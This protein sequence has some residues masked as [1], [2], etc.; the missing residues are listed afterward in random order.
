[1]D[2]TLYREAMARWASGV[3]IIACRHDARVIATTV[4]AFFSLSLEP[5]L[6][7]AAIGPNATVLPF[8]QPHETFGISVL[9]ESQRRIATAYADSFPVI[10]NPFSDDDAPVIAD[11]LVRLHCVVR[12]RIGTGDHELVVANVTDAHFTEEGALVRF[13]RR[14]HAISAR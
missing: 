4:S 8:L 3:T 12:E 2:Q 5:P 13:R 11:A 1:M 6:V 14:Y 9:A 10:V 7:L